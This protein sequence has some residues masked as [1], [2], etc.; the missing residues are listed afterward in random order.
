MY[1]QGQ[2]MP[3]KDERKGGFQTGLRIVKE[4]GEVPA[5]KPNIYISQLVNAK[6]DA[7]MAE[8]PNKEWL[9]YLQGLKIGNNWRIYDISVP[10]QITTIGSVVTDP[11]NTRPKDC[12]GTIHSHGLSEY[13]T[14]FSSVDED[15]LIE[16]YHVSIVTT[17]HNM[18]GTIKVAVPC[19][20]FMVIEVPVLV[21]YPAPDI[22]KWVD[23]AK[24]QIKDPPPRPPV[25]NTTVPGINPVVRCDKCNKYVDIDNAWISENSCICYPCL[26]I[27]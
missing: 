26:G 6:K 2:L 9:A 21:D 3:K 24:K 5:N 25:A 27:E 22:K 4:C 10:L 15:F 23:N 7:M 18:T 20:S 11:D 12:V 1:V 17:G 16:N 19:G 13:K 8:Y 14:G